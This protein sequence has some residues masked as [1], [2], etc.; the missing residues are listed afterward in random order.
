MDKV[1]CFKM[2]E[3]KCIVHERDKGKWKQYFQNLFNECYEI[4]ITI[5]EHDRHYRGG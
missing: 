1:K 5:I 2:E 3:G 4:Y